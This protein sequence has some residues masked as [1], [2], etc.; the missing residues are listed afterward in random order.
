MDGRAIW[1]ALW[2]CLIEIAPS[3]SIHC[4]VTFALINHYFSSGPGPQPLRGMSGFPAQQQAQA[5]NATLASARLPNG[6]LGSGANWNFNL[7]VSGTPGL[8]GNQQRNVGAMGTFAQSLSGGSQPATPLDL[9]DFPSLSGAPQQ[10]QTPNPGLVWG[11]RALQQTPQRQQHPTSQA[12]SRAPQTQS[13]HPQQQS[14]PSHEDV[15]PSGAQFANRLDDFRNGG[16]GISG[17]L[18]GSGQ[19]QTG[20]IDE[21]PPLGRNVAADLGQ[22]RRESLM[23]SAGLGNFG[24]TMPF[25][26]A[27]QNQSAQNRTMIGGSINGQDTSRMMSPT[28]AGSTA[29][30]TSRSPVNQ[31]ANGVPGSEK[32]DLNVT[33][34][35]NQRNFTEQQQAQQPQAAAGEAQDV[36]AAA[37]STEQ[38]PLAQMSEL[39]RFGLA[40]LLR[41]I[42]SD[43][44]DVASLA[45]GQDLMTLGLDLNQPEPLHTS[46]ASPFVASM[47]AVPMEQNFSLPACYS[48]ANI[49]PLQTRIPSFSDETLFYIF[50][51]MPRDIMQELAAEELMGRKWRYHKIERCWLT[52]DETYPGPVDVEPRV[53]ERGVY[54]IWD[55][56]TWKKIRREFILRYEDLDNRL[57]HNRGLARPLGFPHQAS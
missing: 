5:R 38:P 16:Q 52:R 41:M 20:N 50:Y 39:D 27:N 7:P 15:F 37:Q 22:D 34:M 36:A 56:T 19:P 1:L 8:Q 54:L 57:D 49:Q 55:P 44:P 45:V 26:G 2:A 10:S 32:E 40:G 47:S 4:F 13:H 53:S 28:N 48:V 6:K 11:Q 42:H 3:L 46:F 25:T 17:Q 35:A 31:G 51:S 14:Q 30:G 18:G 24:G 9:S 21:F 29:I 12:P 33:T 43:S 23:Q